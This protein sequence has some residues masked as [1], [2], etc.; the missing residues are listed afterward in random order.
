ME[1]KDQVTNLELSKKLKSLGFLN[2]ETSLEIGIKNMVEW[3][4]KVGIRKSK[5]FKNI[6]ITKGLP[7]G[8]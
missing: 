5:K 7:E 4:K 1:L 6:E 8:W 2:T 3:T